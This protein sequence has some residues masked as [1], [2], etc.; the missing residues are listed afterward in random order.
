MS[1]PTV[2]RRAISG[3]R[4]SSVRASTACRPSGLAV[5]ARVSWQDALGNAGFRAWLFNG[6]LR[7]TF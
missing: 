4:S 2:S 1:V 7:Y 6:G 5:Y 3:V